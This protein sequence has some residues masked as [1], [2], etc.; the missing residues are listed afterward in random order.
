MLVATL[1][2]TFAMLYMAF[3]LYLLPYICFAYWVLNALWGNSLFG[4]G[5]IAFSTI[6]FLR[7]NFLDKII[8]LPKINIK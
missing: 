7:M 2:L 3:A 6:K 5:N 4:N 1:A 8:E